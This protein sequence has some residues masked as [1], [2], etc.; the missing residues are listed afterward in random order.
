V[1]AIGESDATVRFGIAQK[2]LFCRIEI[3]EERAA[4]GSVKARIMPQ[5]CHGQTIAPV[6]KIVLKYAVPAPH[7]H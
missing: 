7:T 6:A 1:I 5:L 3:L 2:F 4:E